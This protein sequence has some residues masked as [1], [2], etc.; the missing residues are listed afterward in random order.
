[1]ANRIEGR[2]DKIG[3]TGCLVTDISVD[4]VADIPHDDT[5]TIKFGGHETIGIYPADH[6]QPA[7]TLVASLGKS[8][9]VEIEIVGISL[10]EMLGIK[11][12]EAVAVCW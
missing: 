7:A 2:V 8:G 10:S 11:P 4:Q 1:M 6:D 9:F 12:K 3:E 5:V